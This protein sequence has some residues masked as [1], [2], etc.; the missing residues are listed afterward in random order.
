M[1]S[2]Y[3][4]RL[5]IALCF[6]LLISQF[7]G[8]GGGGG[9]Q[10]SDDGTIA[11]NLKPTVDAGPDQTIT[12]SG[13]DPLTITLSG[14]ASDDDGSIVTHQWQ[15]VSGTAGTLDD[16]STAT[17]SFIAP[18]TTGYYFF[19][20]TAVDDDGA[21]STDTVSVNVTRILFSDAFD[22]GS[23][24]TARWLPVN[25]APTTDW[26]VYNEAL[27]QKNDIRDFE[28]PSS[29]HLGT[30][31]LLSDP[32]PGDIPPD[33][34]FSVD[35]FPSTNLN[36][37]IQQ[38]NDVGIMF[39]YQ[40]PGNYYRV[41][42]S[43]R[44][45]FTRFEKWQG[46]EFSTLAVNAI[47]Y[48]DNQPMTMTAEVKDNKI[49]VWIDGIP[50][51]A[52]VDENPILTGT[53]ALYCQDRVQ[54]DNVEI[55]E[56]LLQPTVVIATPLAYSVALTGDDDDTLDVQAVVLNEPDAA[57]VEFTLYNENNSEKTTATVDNGYHTTRFFGVPP[58]EHDIMAVLKDADGNEVSD[59][60]NSTVGS[61]GGYYVAVGDSITN[62]FGDL[63]STNNES[64]DG[65]I[66]AI[67]G[68]QAPLADILTKATARPQ[69]VFNEGIGGDRA[70]DLLLR[71]DSILERH[72]GSN[73]IL[74]MIGSN[75]AGWGVT[76]TSYNG[77]V[78]TIA[79]KI[80]D[81]YGIPVWMA[82][83][84]PIYVNDSPISWNPDTTK[85]NLIIQY[86]TKLRQ[87]AGIEPLDD[88]F[89]GPN[90]YHGLF[91]D[92]PAEVYNN[93]VHPNDIGY[94]LMAEEWAQKLTQ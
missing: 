38:G 25:A 7:Y 78:E 91:V 88:T 76:S 93:Y 84:M 89:L 56:P 67:Q 12:F 74:M 49:I 64:A 50:V 3:L 62:G 68:F 55:T 30:Y 6:C 66:V 43:A 16:A 13:S 87:I 26:L 60:I 40:G 53:I 54:F 46:G 94:Q 85:N 42:M 22:D 24:W 18:A 31:A 35:I 57:S 73:G 17:A 44:Y 69:I 36:G 10:S 27:L 11:V 8:C 19:S 9:A 52:F 59:D 92:S 63:I 75:D 29:Y 82:E 32:A 37:G 28:G 83:I 1:D 58:G 51:F 33:Y 86:N 5:K 48:V 20:Y 39:R 61:G 21:Q 34:R 15:Q 14:T 47:G 77:T 2:R 90:F 79:E 45:G 65:R 81:F 4:V 23:Q 71:I 70:S 72:P 80:D 41:S